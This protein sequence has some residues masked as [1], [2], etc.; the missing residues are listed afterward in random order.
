MILGPCPGPKP[1]YARTRRLMHRQVRLAQASPAAKPGRPAGWLALVSSCRRPGSA[2]Q[3]RP[4]P[5]GLALPGRWREHWPAPGWPWPV[6]ICSWAS[7]RRRPGRLLI[8]RPSCCPQHSAP[9]PRR[10][11][12]RP[13]TRRA[14]PSATKYWWQD[15][16]ATAK[17]S[18]S[19]VWQSLVCNCALLR[20]E[21]AA[22]SLTTPVTV[23]QMMISVQCALGDR[24]SLELFLFVLL[25]YL[26]VY[27]GQGV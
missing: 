20:A 11:G 10:A 18:Q 22:F 3:L 12:A 23:T 14:A 21:L 26:P 5:I 24:F 19:L 27:L 1:A 13:L 25:F 4:D 16:L 2:R 15:E 17:R 9:T 8:L 6:G 7:S